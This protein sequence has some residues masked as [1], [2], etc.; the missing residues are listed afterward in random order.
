MRVDASAPARRDQRRGVVL[1]DDGRALEG[2]TRLQRGAVID[3]R[4]D[5]RRLVG[6]QDAGVAD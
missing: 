3:R 2:I 1:L 6:Q 4:L 5:R